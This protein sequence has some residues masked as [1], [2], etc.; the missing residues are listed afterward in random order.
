M[1]RGLEGGSPPHQRPGAPILR[2]RPRR[3]S[4]LARGTE[5][6]LQLALVRAGAVTPPELPAPFPFPDPLR[7][8]EEALCLRGPGARRAGDLQG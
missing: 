7:G 8:G 3:K 4:Q 1:D 2:L 5:A 6:R